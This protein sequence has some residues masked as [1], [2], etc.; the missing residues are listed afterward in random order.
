M[1]HVYFVFSSP[2]A[3]STHSPLILSP[4]DPH[5]LPSMQS[6]ML[7]NYSCSILQLL[8]TFQSPGPTEIRA[9]TTGSGTLLSKCPHAN[10]ATR[11][12]SGSS[13][14]TELLPLH[15]NTYLTMLIIEEGARN[16]FL[17]AKHLDFFGTSVQKKVIIHRPKVCEHLLNPET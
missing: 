6:D 3:S 4:L 12:T 11:A 8:H 5:P 16:A 10:Q 9:N 7:G 13:R 14:R 17:L 1:Q 2:Y 15:V